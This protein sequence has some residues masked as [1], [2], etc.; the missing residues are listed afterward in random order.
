M[1]IRDL[2][3]TA[4]TS[5]THFSGKVSAGTAVMMGMAVCCPEPAKEL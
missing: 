2:L 1:H 5:S 3:L 4:L